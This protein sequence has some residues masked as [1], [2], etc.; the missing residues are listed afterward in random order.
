MSKE[1]TL[2]IYKLEQMRKGALTLNREKLEKRAKAK[3][4]QEPLLLALLELKNSKLAKNYHDAFFCSSV[5]T[6]KGD[7]LTSRYCKNRFCR[8]CNRIA[9]GKLINNYAPILDKLVDKQFVTL[10][11]PNVAAD[12]LRAAIMRMNKVMRL[13]QDKRRKAKLPLIKGI[14]KLE[15]TYNTFANNYHPHFHLIIENESQAID[16]INQWLFYYPDSVAKA[17]HRAE[18]TEC[19]ELFKYFTKLT[20]NTGSTF[21]N[22]SKVIDEWQFPESIDVIF[23]NIAKLRIIQSMGGIALIDDSIDGLESQTIDKVTIKEYNGVY[24]WHNDNWYDP[25]TGEMI[26]YFKPKENLKKY[27]EKIRYLQKEE[28][29]E[30]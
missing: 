1:N 9:T 10:T 22:G 14:R 3:F 13:I 26:T 4:S 16:L 23:T 2:L 28:N 20:S 27:R 5:L 8:V 11:I 25:Y 18:A 12:K 19:I 17:Q 15:C 30:Q 29:H 7:K 21:E 24:F 6:Q